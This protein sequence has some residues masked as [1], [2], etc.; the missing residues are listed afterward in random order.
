MTLGFNDTG[1]LFL[2]VG[3]RSSIFIRIRIIHRILLRHFENRFLLYRRRNLRFCL[4]IDGRFRFFFYWCG[5][6]RFFIIRYI[7]RRTP[8]TVIVNTVYLRNFAG[9]FSFDLSGKFL[10]KIHLFGHVHLRNINIHDIRFNS[11]KELPQ[12]NLNIHS[13]GCSLLW[14][15]L[16][17]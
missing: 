10:H 13:R 17:A 14:K 15:H 7:R 5:D 8:G 9:L 1:K 2:V 12:R 16:S 3:I 6:L 11:R 4:F